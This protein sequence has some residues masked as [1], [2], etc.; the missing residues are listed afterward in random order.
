MTAE[1]QYLWNYEKIYSGSTEADL[2]SSSSPV[3]IGRYGQNGQT[4][5]EGRG[6]SS[7]TEHYQVSSS[8]TTPPSTWW[9]PGVSSGSMP[10]T[11]TTNKYLWNYETITYTSG[12]PAT[13]DTEKRVIGTHGS[14]GTN[15]GIVWLYKRA[16][17]TPVKPTA[18]LVYNFS[19][20]KI[21][22]S[23]ADLAG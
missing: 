7:I 12:T 17:S 2:I 6:I 19:T 3:I 11:T 21:T 20:G 23:T 14:T 16:T 18:T 22:N 8:N 13:E 4:G 9:T 1:K 15:T 5:P 10:V